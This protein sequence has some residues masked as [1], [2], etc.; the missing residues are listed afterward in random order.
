MLIGSKGKLLHDTYGKNPK[1]LP[2]SLN[3][4]FGTPQQKLPRIADESH[5]MNWVNAAKGLTAASCPF[6]YAAQLTEVMLL[7]IV[8]L[9]T[10]RKIEYDAANMR[11]VNV[12][13]ANEYLRRQPRSGWSQ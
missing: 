12:P 13:A 7:G 10:G 1:L 9:K 11:V 5:E 6:A 3:E 8:A 2:L 4:S